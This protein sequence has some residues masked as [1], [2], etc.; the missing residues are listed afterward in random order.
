MWFK[1][2]RISRSSIRSRW[3]LPVDFL[4]PMI[5]FRSC[6]IYLLFC[7]TSAM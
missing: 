4:A 6:Y 1:W 5:V 2:S 7:K 3:C